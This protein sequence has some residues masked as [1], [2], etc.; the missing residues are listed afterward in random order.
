M[1]S[2]ASRTPACPEPQMLA[3]WVLSSD[4]VGLRHLS[5]C[6]NCIR[7]AGELDAVATLLWTCADEIFDPTAEPGVELLGSVGPPVAR[8][9]RRPPHGRPEVSPALQPSFIR[10]RPRRVVAAILAGLGVG[11]GAFLATPVQLPQGGELRGQTMMLIATATFEPA[12]ETLRLVWRAVP[13]VDR[14]TV[15][16]WNSEGRL[17]AERTLTSR[18]T[19]IDLS[20]RSGTPRVYWAVDAWAG[21]S[22]V[23]RSGMGETEM[24]YR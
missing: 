4:P 17:L 23:G 20:I 3:E 6:P 13:G 10:N 8:P 22:R 24:S 16:A 18:A 9:P 15:R 12:T 2:T 11:I 1:S 19:A 21:H 7:T 5:Q 14:Y